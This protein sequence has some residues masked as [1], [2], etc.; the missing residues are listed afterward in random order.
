MIDGNGIRSV[1]R[2]SFSVPGPPTWYLV[3]YYIR[4]LVPDS[5]APSTHLVL[6]Y[7]CILYLYLSLRYETSTVLGYEYKSNNDNF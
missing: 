1:T 4:V 2:A 6:L 5:H 7:V 3:F